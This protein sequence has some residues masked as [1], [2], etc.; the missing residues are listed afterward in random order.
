MFNCDVHQ[1]LSVLNSAAV[2][3]KMMNTS[4]IVLLKSFKNNGPMT[5]QGTINCVKNLSCFY[6]RAWGKNISASEIHSLF[7]SFF[8]VKQIFG[9]E[10][11]T[12]SFYCS[13]D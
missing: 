2:S 10:S 13:N 1:T 4:L 3:L 5:D 8:G 12:Q 9:K 11:R 6:V 7:A